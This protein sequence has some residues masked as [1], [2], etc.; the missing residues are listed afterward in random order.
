MV[1][2]YI[3]HRGIVVDISMNFIVDLLS[4]KVVHS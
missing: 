1:V 3:K 2:C 4:Y